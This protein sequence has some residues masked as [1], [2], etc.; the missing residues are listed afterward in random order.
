MPWIV[1]DPA[2]V[3]T[4]ARFGLI[5]TQTSHF[6]LVTQLTTTSTCLKMI[7]VIIPTYNEEKALP[8][9]LDALLRQRGEYEVIVVDGGSTDRTRDIIQAEP[10][11]RY[12]TA[13]RGRALQ[14]NSAARRARGDWLLFL[15]A[16]TLLPDGALCLL[17]SL[18]NDAACQAGGFRHCFTGT[19][20]RLRMISRLDNLRA[21]LT[22]IIYGDQA[23]FVKRR[24]F[25]Q[26][27]GFPEQ[28]VLEDLLFSKKL[29]RVT[30]PIILNQCV[31]TDS[32]KFV[33]M[34]IWRSLARCLIILLC[35]VFKLPFL[36]KRFFADIR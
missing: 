2:P 12:E 15:H 27:G 23:L 29:K 10:L 36:P 1:H 9:I 31:V 32:R 8:K 18:E 14:M 30:R 21:R 24:L 22:R 5:L 35:H 16:D 3:S 13:P 6:D 20:W 19:D 34:G 26:L 11:L 33:Q 4:G 28:P 25:E 7:S 17:N